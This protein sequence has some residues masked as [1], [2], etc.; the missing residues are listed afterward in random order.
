[1]VDNVLLKQIQCKVK[2]LGISSDSRHLKK[3]DIF[4]AI[5]GKSINGTRFIDLAI[6]KGAVAIVV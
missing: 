4:F 1:M 3:G 5:N 6:K 2:V